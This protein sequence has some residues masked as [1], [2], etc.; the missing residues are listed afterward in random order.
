VVA[1]ERRDSLFFEH[2][3]PTTRFVDPRLCFQVSQNEYLNLFGTFGDPAVLYYVLYKLLGAIDQ[4]GII[5]KTCVAFL[6]LTLEETCPPEVLA[7]RLSSLKDGDTLQ[8]VLECV[9][10]REVKKVYSG[11]DGGRFRAGRVTLKYQISSWHNS[12]FALKGMLTF[13]VR[14]QKM[15]E[16]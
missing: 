5:H 1:V 13:L 11:K 4:Y 3:F 2:F 14:M 12:H 7:E 9:D 6:E 10:T 16:N 8:V 15:P